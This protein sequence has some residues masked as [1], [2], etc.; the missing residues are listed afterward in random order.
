MRH[1]TAA[2]LIVITSTKPFLRVVASTAA[3]L[4]V[5]TGTAPFLI[6]KQEDNNVPIYNQE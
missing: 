1:S 6:V 3:C 2:G 5:I 4:V